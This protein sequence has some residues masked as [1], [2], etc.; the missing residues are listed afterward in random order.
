MHIAA[1]L[2][3]HNRR[4][5]TL[6]CLRCLAAQELPDGVS[7]HVTLVDDGSSDG[8]AAA[9]AEAYP[10]TRLLHGSGYLFWCGGM[11][12]AW[13]TADK[14]APD[15]YLLANDDTHLDRDALQTLLAMVGTPDARIIAVAAIRDPTSGEL[16]YGGIR[17]KSGRVPA[18]GKV[19]ACDTFNANAVLIPNAV[20]QELGSFHPAYTHG[21]GD[22]DYGYLASRNGISILQSAHTLGNC[23]HNS[24]TGTWQDRSLPMTQRLRKLHSPKGLPFKEWAVYC[25]RNSGWLWPYRM[26]SPILRILLGR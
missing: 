20:Y 16:N 6:E 23:G 19:E 7:I 14:D 13:S 5:K 11:R 12:L 22:F 25:R 1:L 24:C 2:T 4:E 21:M 18:T 10:Q 15:Y 9:V 26:I 3:C 17:R 8:T